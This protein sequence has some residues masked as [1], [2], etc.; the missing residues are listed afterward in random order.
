MLDAV[1]LKHFPALQRGESVR[2]D[3]GQVSFQT[4]KGWGVMHPG[5]F[6]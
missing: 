6:F 2:I 1:H 5:P 3:T 4:D